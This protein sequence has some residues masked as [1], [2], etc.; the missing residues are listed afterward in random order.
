MAGLAESIG[1]QARHV[2]ANLTAERNHRTLE[3][4]ALLIVALALPELGIAPPVAELHDNLLTDFGL[5]GVHRE[6]STHYHLIALRSFVGAR[7]NCRR[8]GVA[9]PAGFDERLDARVRVRARLPPPRRHDPGALGQ[10]HRRLRRVAGLAGRLLSRDDLLD[11][12]AEHV[13]RRRLRDPA[14]RRPL[15]DPRLRPARRR[16]PRP[17]RRAQRRGVGGRPR[18]GAWTP[19][20]S[21]TPRASRTCAT[22]SAGPRR[23]TPSASTAPIRRRTR[24][25][26]RR[27]RRPR[28]ACSNASA[29]RPRRRGPQP[30]LRGD[31]PPPRGLRRRPLLADRGRPHRRAA[32]PLRPALAPRPRAASELW[33]D[34]VTS[35]TVAITILGA[36]SI[37]LEDGWISPRYGIREPAP[38]V[39]AVATGTERALH[40][41]ARAARARRAGPDPERRRRHRVRRRRAS[42]AAMTELA[43]DPAVPRRNALL[44]PL[45]MAEVLSQRL[46]GGVP[47]ERCERTYVK[48]RVGDS[49]RV[50]YRYEVDGV[51]RHVSA[52]TQAHRA[53]AR[54]ARARGRRR[55]VPVPVRPQ[56][57]RAAG[58]GARLAR[59]RE[60]ARAAGHAAAGVL[61]R[62]AVGRGRVR[63][64]R[65]PRARVRQGPARRR[66]AAR[67]RGAG[68]PGRRARAARTGPTRATCWCSRRSRAAA[69]TTS[70]AATRRAL[71]GARAHASAACTRW[72]LD[73]PPLRAPRP[74]AAGDRRRRDR[75]RA[76]GRRRRPPSGCWRGSSRSRRTGPR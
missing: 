39:S 48:Y 17:L 58:A 21:R 18:A 16:R 6:R 20:A 44:R 4:Y 24:A 50:V 38:V 36:R 72:P 5:D 30:G 33:A 74:V 71:H 28:R 10:R 49:L 76:A 2:R 11:G 12:Q 53:R 37:A 57:A 19:A 68:R 34:G 52:R 54:R 43:P 1:E 59:A 14:R 47:V 55:A 8:F 64:R 32:A 75:A 31:P 13:R 51:T 67:D 40:H 62:R 23:T 9:L 25:G 56:A 3:L 26:A 45:T 65:R 63:R 60:P 46:H 70:T 29:D 7:E 66:R 15:P 41:A 73:A 69:S 22:G 61:R 35:P 27:S 42:R